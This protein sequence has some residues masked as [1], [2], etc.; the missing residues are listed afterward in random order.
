MTTDTTPKQA[1]KKQAP[2]TNKKREQVF[3]NDENVLTFYSNNVTTLMT[4]WDFKL[5]FGEIKEATQDKLVVWNKASVF[6]SPQHA[7]AVS[8][9]LAKQIALYEEK[10]GGIVHE[11][12]KDEEGSLSIPD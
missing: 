12:K 3:L 4:I 8:E 7:K 2:R 11:S 6:M 5:T 1:H 9:L 10:F